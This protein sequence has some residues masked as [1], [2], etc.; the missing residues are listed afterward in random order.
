MLN[1]KECRL[2]RDSNRTRRWRVVAAL[3]L[4]AFA[5]GSAAE[6]AIARH[7]SADAASPGGFKVDGLLTRDGNG[8]RYTYHVP[9]G[10]EA[11]FEIASDPNQLRDV[12]RT[13][14][15]EARRLRRQLETKLNVRDLDELRAD[16][17]DTIERLHALGYL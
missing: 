2:S 11:L 6:I 12:L 4:I 15:D 14:R 8:F 3:A 16:Y 9:T 7:A 13:H 5:A 10:A 1:S 17:K